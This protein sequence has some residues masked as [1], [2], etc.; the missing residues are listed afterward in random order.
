MKSLFICTLLF[1]VTFLPAQDTLA[2]TVREEIESDTAEFRRDYMHIYY[3]WDSDYRPV[4]TED[5]VFDAY[6]YNWKN[7]VTRSYTFA[8]GWT[9]FFTPNFSGSVG[10]EVKFISVRTDSIYLAND[11]ENPIIHSGSTH[12]INLPFCARYSFGK[13]IRIGGYGGTALKLKVDDSGPMRNIDRFNMDVRA[14]VFAE[15][16]F[17]RM[18]LRIMPVYRIDLFDTYK[19][20]KW[21]HASSK[22]LVLEIE[23]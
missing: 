17:K 6:Q 12:Y 9:H 14:G 18:R 7:G 15:Y 11:P 10:A 16:N 5:G 19:W 1:L 20:A 22:G 4:F 2:P 23:F 13:K 21:K 8:M 3:S